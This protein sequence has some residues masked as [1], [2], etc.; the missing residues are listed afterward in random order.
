MNEQV[1]VTIGHPQSRIPIMP[2]VAVQA[3]SEQDLREQ[4]K[5]LRKV[6]ADNAGHYGFRTPSG[7][8][9]TFKPSELYWAVFNTIDGQAKPILHSE[10]YYWGVFGADLRQEELPRFGGNWYDTGYIEAKQGI[11]NPPKDRYPALVYNEGQADYR[12]SVENLLN[13]ENS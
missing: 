10:N 8:S 1:Y 5:K 6:V 11:Q 2:L 9:V 12:T 13:A 3:D 7:G 4:A